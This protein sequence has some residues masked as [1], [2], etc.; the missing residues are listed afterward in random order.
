MSIA[1][2][3]IGIAEMASGDEKDTFRVT[4]GSCVGI[5]IFHCPSARFAVAHVLL[6]RFEGKETFKPCNHSGCSAPRCIKVMNDKGT[7]VS[8][9]PSS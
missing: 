3:R 8:A 7:P 4:L 6:P 9:S 5:C 1:G 2:R